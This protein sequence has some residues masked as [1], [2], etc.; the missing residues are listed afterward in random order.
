VAT[1]S[2]TLKHTAIAYGAFV[3]FLL[4]CLGFSLALR[5]RL[6]QPKPGGVEGER[7][8]AIEEAKRK[9]DPNYQFTTRKVPLPLA[10]AP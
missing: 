3:L 2:K 5:A 4:G 6:S 7:L 9:G 1:V 10:G 8:Q